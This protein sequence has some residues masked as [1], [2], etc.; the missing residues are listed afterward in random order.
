[1]SPP[2]AAAASRLAAA[3][4]GGQ[5]E[6][7]RRGRIEV[8][9]GEEFYEKMR[10]GRRAGM[11]DEIQ[12]GLP[13]QRWRDAS[14]NEIR[15]QPAAQAE[16]NRLG[17]TCLEENPFKL[18][19]VVGSERGV[20]GY[21][22][23]AVK[24]LRSRWAMGIAALIA[25]Y[26]PV[27]VWLPALPVSGSPTVWGYVLSPVAFPVMLWAL[28]G[29]RVWVLLALVI[30]FGTSAAL[31]ALSQRWRWV[32]WTIPCLLFSASL[33]QGWQ[34]VALMKLFQAIGLLR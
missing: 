22:S 11:D 6:G 24:I 8:G 5:H 33:W 4:S 29:V 32:Q 15:V 21:R 26:A 13:Q 9:V 10:I 1:L 18:V 28:G 7:E 30:I 3:A 19:G 14:V 31:L 25:S 16:S 27:L 17:P 20:A 2:A 12:A 34:F 23:L